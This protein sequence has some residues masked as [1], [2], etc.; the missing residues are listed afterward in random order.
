MKIAHLRITLDHEHDVIREL[1]IPCSAKLIDLHQWILKSFG[2]SG[3]QMSSF[4]LSDEAWEKGEEIVLF[5]MEFESEG[6]EEKKRTME[7]LKIEEAIHPLQPNL[8]YVYDFLRMWVFYV[9]W[10][11]ESSECEHMRYPSIIKSIGNA[12]KEE[13]KSMDFEMPVELLNDGESEDPELKEI[14]DRMDSKDKD[15]L[16]PDEYAQFE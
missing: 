10:I 13:E 2:F 12:P 14:L 9:E 8:L 3:E 7:E 4:Y 16:D 1:E 15:H 11:N 5:D 6:F